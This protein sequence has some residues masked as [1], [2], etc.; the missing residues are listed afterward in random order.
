MDLCPKE[1]SVVVLQKSKAYQT[2]GYL[3]E[4]FGFGASRDPGPLIGLRVGG[5]IECGIFSSPTSL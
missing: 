4:K 1:G 5:L 3:E 2:L